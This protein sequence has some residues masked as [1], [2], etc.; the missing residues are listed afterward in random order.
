MHLLGVNLKITR[1]HEFR[2]G[3]LPFELYYLL[4]K[5]CLIF[6]SLFL[7]ANVHTEFLSDKIDHEMIPLLLLASSAVTVPL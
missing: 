2:R 4:W 1:K 3:S 5:G 6:I 7:K